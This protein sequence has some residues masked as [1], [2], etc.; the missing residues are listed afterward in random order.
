MNLHTFGRLDIYLLLELLALP[1]PYSEEPNWRA[2]LPN[3]KA[4]PRLLICVSAL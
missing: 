2:A 3:W 1:S 4:Q